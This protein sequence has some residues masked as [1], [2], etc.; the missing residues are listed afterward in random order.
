MS[1]ISDMVTIEAFIKTQFPSAITGK[2][3]VPL[4]PA[5]GSFY[6]RMIDE[7]RTTET[8]YHYRVDRVYQIVHV[9]VRPDMVLADMDALGRAIY[10]DELIGHIRVNAYSVSQP[11]LTD[12]GLYAIIGILDTSVRESRDQTVYP[13]IDNVTV[14]RV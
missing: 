6:V 7:D 14:R 10:Q 8:R 13:K 2:Q 11:A 1:V 4:Q 12:N 3:V 5:A 9:T